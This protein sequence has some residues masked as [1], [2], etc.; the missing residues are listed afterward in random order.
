[1]IGYCRSNQLVFGKWKVWPV[2]CG[3]AYN[4][5]WNYSILFTLTQRILQVYE[6]FLICC[7]NRRNKHNA[8]TAFICYPSKHIS[9]IL[10]INFYVSS[11]KEIQP[12]PQVQIS[13]PG[14]LY[15]HYLSKVGVFSCHSCI[16]NILDSK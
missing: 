7:I 3:T 15:V 2:S 1:M 9:A 12:L 5:Y 4:M 13:W 10:Y 16:H 11:K 14:F 6:N 8:D